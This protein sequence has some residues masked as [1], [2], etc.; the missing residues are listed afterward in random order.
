ME[1]VVAQ[2]MTDGAIRQGTVPQTLFYLRVTA[3]ATGT[4]GCLEINSE[5]VYLLVHFLRYSE[6]VTE[7]IRDSLTVHL[8]YDC[9]ANTYYHFNDNQK[10]CLGK[11]PSEILP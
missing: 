7:N 8:I 3:E 6:N 11:Y 10:I 2:K 5:H 1:T 9:S 4:R